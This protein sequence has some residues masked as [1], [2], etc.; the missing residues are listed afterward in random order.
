MKKRI[1]LSVLTFVIVCL[2]LVITSEILK[3]K[4]SEVKYD[5]FYQE[6][7]KLDVLFYGSSIVHYGIYPMELWEEYGI[8]SYNMGN[9]S[10]RLAMTYFT[11]LNSLDYSSPKAV[12]ID[13]G[14]LGWAGQR[15][16]GTLKD[17]VFLDSVPM[18]YHKWK[19]ITELFEEDRWLEFFFPGS[20]YHSRW[21]ELTEDDIVKEQSYTRGADI[22]T[23]VLMLEKPTSDRYEESRY[24]Y[25]DYETENLLAMK[26]LC[27]QRNIEMIFIFMPYEIR[28][29]DQKLREFALEFTQ[30]NNIRY[31]DLQELD[32]VDWEKGFSDESHLNYMGAEAMTS[33]IGKLLTTE[34]DIP[35]HKDDV[36]YHDWCEDYERYVAYKEN[37]IGE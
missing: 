28:G 35:S 3:V 37:V 24:E 14:G 15:V 4:E 33:Y 22:L 32:I 25:L 31:Y 13:L 21:A 36:K 17:H 29:G 10:E 7:E 18:S 11:L 26:A 1:V 30:K 2:A 19:T 23:Q 20:V 9:N 16:D 27:E 5:S 12:V 8:T 6:A 34:Y